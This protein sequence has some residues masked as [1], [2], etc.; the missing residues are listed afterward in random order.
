MSTDQDEQAARQNNSA[1]GPEERRPWVIIV[2]LVIIVVGVAVAAFVSLRNVEK[3]PTTSEDIAAAAIGVWVTDDS[4]EAV[5]IEFTSSNEY[6]IRNFQGTTIL[7]T[8]T[9]NDDGLIEA[10]VA[11]RSYEGT[12]YFDPVSADELHLEVSELEI[13][14]T[15]DRTE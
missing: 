4:P 15:L 10:P 5:T 3:A 12:W 8:W 1:D 7:G 9:V 2:F 6:G 11:Y 13:D 14:W